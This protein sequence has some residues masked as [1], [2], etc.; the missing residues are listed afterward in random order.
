MELL[1]VAGVAA[2][3]LLLLVA[4]YFLLQQRRSGTVK[5]VSAPRR[6]RDQGTAHET[7]EGPDR[8]AVGT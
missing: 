1:I 8:E 3:V 4:G 2:L 6:H 7:D 5:A